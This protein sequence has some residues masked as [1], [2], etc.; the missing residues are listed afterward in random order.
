MLVVNKNGTVRNIDDSQLNEYKRKGYTQVVEE[1]KK[2][3]A[4]QPKA[5]TTTTR[6]NN[7]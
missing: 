1:E 6:K 4:E 7:K 5:T 3:I 2:V